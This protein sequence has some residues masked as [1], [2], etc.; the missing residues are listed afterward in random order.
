MH[1]LL[2]SGLWPRIRQLAKEAKRKSA[3]VAY[4]T[5]DSYI[6]F[7]DGDTLVAD[8]SDEA[9]KSGQTSARVLMEAF[10][11][12]AQ[13]ASIT[14]L[15]SKV[16]VFDRCAIIGSANLSKES[17]Q[18]T[19]AALVTDQPAIVSSARLL[20]EQLKSAGDVVDD[21]FISRISKLPV[22]KRKGALTGR[23]RKRT[24][25][26][27]PRSWLVG[28]KSVEEKEAEKA[29]VEEGLFEVTLDSAEK[30]KRGT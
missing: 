9:I 14:G 2:S 8:A 25:D 15:H 6:K 18:R 20:I 30:Q 16:Y 13:I 3:A 26:T 27:V 17:E 19:E 1:E 11:R 12:G 5:D 4:V 29:V 24:S 23:K 21:S 10:K 7:G 22:T 28:L